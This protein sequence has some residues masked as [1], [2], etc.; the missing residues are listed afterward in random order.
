[1]THKTPPITHSYDT[2]G[3][4]ATAVARAA[5]AEAAGERASGIGKLVPEDLLMPVHTSI[6]INLCIYMGSREEGGL[7]SWWAPVCTLSLSL[8]ITQSHT[9]THTHTHSL[10]LSLSLSPTH[11]H[12]LTYKRTPHTHRHAAVAENGLAAREG[13]WT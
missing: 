13:C 9:H 10:S 11:P 5:L 8:L 3:A 12:L 4:D 1:M 2:F 7:A 6:G